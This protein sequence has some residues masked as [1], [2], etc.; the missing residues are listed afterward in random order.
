MLGAVTQDCLVNVFLAVLVLRPQ[1]GPRRGFATSESFG[2]VFLS[3]WLHPLGICIAGHLP[4]LHLCQDLELGWFVL[5]SPY[6]LKPVSV[7]FTTIIESFVWCLA[8]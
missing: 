6:P 8:L 5:V 2:K 1:L 3:R 4:C 7:R